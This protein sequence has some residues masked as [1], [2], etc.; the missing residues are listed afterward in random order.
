MPDRQLEAAQ[1]LAAATPNPTPSGT[2]AEPSTAQPARRNRG[3]SP[4]VTTR[5]PFAPPLPPATARRQLLSP[6]DWPAGLTDDA[7][8]RAGEITA[9]YLADVIDLLAL[10][11]SHDLAH[12]DQ[13]ERETLR[14]LGAATVEAASCIGWRPP[15]APPATFGAPATNEIEAI[16]LAWLRHHGYTDEQIRIAGTQSCHDAGCEPFDASYYGAEFAGQTTY[17]CIDEDGKSRHPLRD[18]IAN[19]CDLANVALEA[20]AEYRTPVGYITG[21]RSDLSDWLI[22]YDGQPFPTQQAA[23]DDCRDAAEHTIPG[24][25]PRVLTVYDD[26]DEPHRATPA[27][28]PTHQRGD[29]IT[30]LAQLL[31]LPARTVL[32]IRDGRAARLTSFARRNSDAREAHLENCEGGRLL[33]ARHLP[34]TILSIGDGGAE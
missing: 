17:N 29:S 16:A 4:T 15:P 14:I 8:R 32:E 10:A 34:A 9:D 26:T 3:Y 21:Y 25:T 23:L 5:S 24:L 28:T 1:R 13:G 11:E 33:T 12:G 19:A 31:E 27:T 2:P 20:L 7:A 30:E 18:E 22:E 6:A